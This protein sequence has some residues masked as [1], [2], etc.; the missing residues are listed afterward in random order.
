MNKLCRFCKKES[1]YGTALICRECNKKYMREYYQK[2]RTHLREK[3]KERGK[4]RRLNQDYIATE[5]KR[6][7]EI[8]ANLRHEAIMAYGGY[9][10]KCCGITEPLFLTI[11]HVNND[12]AKH[13]R[14]IGYKTGNGKGASSATVR[15]L[16]KN[17]YPEG[18][19][20]LCLNCNMGKERNKGTCPHKQIS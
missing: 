9:I 13:R 2:N 3:E 20:I 8:W 11:D 6:G 14:E 19:Q 4:R 12:G 15:W 10:C 1:D 16:K 5:R 17:N 18:F 7:R